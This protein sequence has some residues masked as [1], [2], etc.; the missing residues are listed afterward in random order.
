MPESCAG[1]RASETSFFFTFPAW[2]TVFFL[3][4]ASVMVTLNLTW[5]GTHTEISVVI[6]LVTEHPG[7]RES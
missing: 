4:P 3:T 5:P 2:R 1:V 7:T 6:S